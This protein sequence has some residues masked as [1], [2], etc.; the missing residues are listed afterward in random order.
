MASRRT[1]R[2]AFSGASVFLYSYSSDVVF[3]AEEKNIARVR[4][5]RA[6][7]KEESVEEVK[8]GEV[9]GRVKGCGGQGEEDRGNIF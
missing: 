3:A 6:R 8:V 9:E 4:R 2:F 5:I 7:W 1:K